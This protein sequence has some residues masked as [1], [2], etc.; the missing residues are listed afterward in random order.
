MWKYVSGSMAFAFR[1]G[2]NGSNGKW[3][4]VARHLTRLSISKLRKS[5][6]KISQSSQWIQFSIFVHWWSPNSHQE[7][8]S[9]IN[10]YSSLTHRLYYI[11]D[12]IL[13][14]FKLLDTPIDSLSLELRIYKNCLAFRIVRWA[15]AADSF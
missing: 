10:I 12:D 4:I 13:N 3:L 9:Q 8:Q 5:S 2:R 6:Y 14:F 11:Y 15:S 7:T 1:Q